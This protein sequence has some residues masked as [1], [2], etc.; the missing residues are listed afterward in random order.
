VE[1]KTRGGE[2]RDLGIAERFLKQ[3]RMVVVRILA[4]VERELKQMRTMVVY[5]QLHLHPVEPVVKHQP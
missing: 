4:L 2:M 3:M 1:E 5:Q